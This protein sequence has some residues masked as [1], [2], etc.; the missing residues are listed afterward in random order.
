MGWRHYVPMRRHCGI[1]IRRR[2]DVPLRRLGDVSLRRRC[3]FHLRP[4]CDVTETQRD[5]VTTSLRRLVVGWE[6]FF[7]E[8]I[9]RIV[10]NNTFLVTDDKILT[11]LIYIYIYIYIYI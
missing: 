11:T 9:E 3:V 1:P 2:K 7:F 4:T 8:M 10:V 5:V 6:F